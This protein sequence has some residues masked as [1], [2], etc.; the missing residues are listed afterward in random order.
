ML[1]SLYRRTAMRLKG[2]ADGGRGGF[3]CIVCICTQEKIVALM[4]QRETKRGQPRVSIG[5]GGSPAGA[6]WGFRR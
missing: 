5:S 3:E 2:K 6:V 4:K 1:R